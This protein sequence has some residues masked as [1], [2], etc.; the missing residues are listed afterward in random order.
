MLGNGGG[1]KGTPGNLLS[2]A[3]KRNECA[4]V[5]FSGRRWDALGHEG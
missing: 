1:H 2:W 5:A 3:G 4:Y